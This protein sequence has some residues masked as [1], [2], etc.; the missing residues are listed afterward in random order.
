MTETLMGIGLLLMMAVL[1]LL[2]LLT[3]YRFK[4]VYRKLNWWRNKA[5]KTN[6]EL[7]NLGYKMNDAIRSKGGSTHE[8]SSSES[9]PKN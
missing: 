1:M 6:N 9:S 2:Q 8:L 7:K 4:G 5:V 3:L